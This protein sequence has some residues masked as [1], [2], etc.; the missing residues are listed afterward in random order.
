VTT[1]LSEI[2]SVGEL[3]A[4]ARHELFV[5]GPVAEVFEMTRDVT[6]W[7]EYMPAVTAAAFIAQSDTGDIVEITAE[8][9]DQKH[10]WRSERSI[11]RTQWTIDFSRVGAAP[12]LLTMTGRWRFIPDGEGTRAVLIHQYATTTPEALRFFDDA[13]RSNATRDLQGLAEYFDRTRSA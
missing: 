6:R 11:D 9:N 1:V 10:T 3:A 5:P 4:R 13:T 2:S 7:H 12:P 8:A